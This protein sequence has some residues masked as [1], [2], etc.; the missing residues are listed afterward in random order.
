MQK[1]REELSRELRR[2]QLEGLFR[3][4]RQELLQGLKYNDICQSFKTSELAQKLS[5]ALQDINSA[6][7]TGEYQ[8]AVSI[9]E[10]IINAAAERRREVSVFLQLLGGQ[11]RQLLT[12][13]VRNCEKID[14]KHE[15]VVLPV[16]V[17][18]KVME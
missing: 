2:N 9:M 5:A 11:V 6:L 16:N 1:R 3:Q 10:F 8:V 17:Q 15:W 14:E 4:R 12:D 18:L 7:K 13:V